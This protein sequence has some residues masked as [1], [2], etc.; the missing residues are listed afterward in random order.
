MAH[1]KKQPTS[2]EKMQPTLSEVGASGGC[3]HL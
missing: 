3:S 1:K 2:L